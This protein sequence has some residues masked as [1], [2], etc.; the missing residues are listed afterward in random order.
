M[1]VPI[2]IIGDSGTGK[3]AGTRTFNKGEVEIVNV[4]NKLMPY[5]DPK[6]DTV[7]VPQLAVEHGNA[8]RVDIVRS[9]LANHHEHKAVVVDDAG[10]LISEMY[11]RWTTGDE[12][13]SD[14]YGVYKEIAARM[15]NLF[16]RVIEDGDVER[17]VY[18]TFHEETDQY[19]KTDI[20][21][22]GKLLNEKLVIRGL[23]TCTLQSAKVGDQYGFHTN[24]ANPAKSPMGLFDDEF[25]P[26]DLRMVDARIREA[27]GMAPLEAVKSND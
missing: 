19:G 26:N 3:T 11:M 22:V 24:N 18:F 2:I 9:W 27:Y 5:F 23:V 21:T 8:L 1:S 4:Q 20:K 17:I 13:M 16:Q 10:Y 12:K 15:W 6:P 7:N 14:Q 25:I